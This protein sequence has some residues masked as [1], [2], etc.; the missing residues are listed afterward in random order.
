MKERLRFATFFALFFICFWVSG[1]LA[2]TPSPQIMI[3]LDA[4]GSMYGKINGQAKID[5]AKQVIHKIVPAISPK[6]KVGLSAYGHHRK[7]DCS[8]M[9]IILKPGEADR[10]VLLQRMDAISPKGMTPIAR[11]ITAVAD[12]LKGNEAETTI[13]L[14]SD[15]KET[16]SPD[17]C[18]VV[19][20]LK[21]SGIKFVLDVIGF[22]VSSEE[23][24][25][26][27]CMANAGGGKYYGADDASSL[28]AALKDVK[29]E[30]EKRI[31]PAKSVKKSAAIGLG[32]L[33][34]EFNKHVGGSIFELKV[35]NQKTNKV[36]ARKEFHNTYVPSFKIPLLSGD[37]E[38]RSFC[39][40]LYRENMGEFVVGRV[41]IEKGKTTVYRPGV[42]YL[43][44][45]KEM[46][47]P[48]ITGVVYEK[49]DEPKMTMTQKLTGGYPYCVRAP[50]ALIPGRYN[51]TINQEV[52]AI[53]VAKDLEVKE[54]QV[55]S[56]D[57]DTGFVV[58]KASDNV[59]G[60]RLVR[61]GETSP[62]LDVHRDFFRDILFYGKYIVEPGSYDLY[63]YVKGLEEPLAVANGLEI[64]K[65]QVLEFDATI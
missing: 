1:A 55:S 46:E 61:S 29:K 2:S 8:D 62:V 30:V 37:Y 24:E 33:D 50:R 60:Y 16:C 17:P 53:T 13:I 35:I 7:G 31:E 42:I 6:V 41:H 39:C 9:E 14:V 51:V 18:G 44:F 63:L 11:S 20:S 36:V 48:I 59:V 43:N 15:G 28:L 23:K 25:Q 38:I 54:G 3:I 26:L 40:G 12:T 45:S 5:V 57:I 47:F 65:G 10:K 34:V 27:M 4:S 56:I 58:K 49:I 64:T 22:D 32:K 52:N 21:A 19:R